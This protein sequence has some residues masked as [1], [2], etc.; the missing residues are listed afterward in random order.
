MSVGVMVLLSACLGEPDNSFG[1]RLKQDINSI[2]AHLSSNGLLDDAI[3]DI[4]GVRYTIET[5]G[6]GY[7]PRITDQVTFDYVGKL[8]DGTVFDSGTLTDFLITNLIPGFQV[9]LPQITVGSSA[10]LYIPSGYGYGAQ[11]K[12]NIPINSILIFSI[13]LKS[14]KLGPNELTRLGAD[15]TAIDNYIT[16]E[17]IE[18]VQKDTTG[19]RYKITEPGIGVVPGLY[20]RVKISYS[21]YLLTNGTKGAK[22]YQGQNQPTSTTDSRVANYIRGFQY[23]LM[24]LPK[25]SK[26]TF[27]IPSG[28]GFGEQAVSGALVPI[29]AN[30]ILIYDVELIDVYDPNP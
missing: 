29:P 2:D 22:F 6:T 1:E 9:G 12:P 16:N 19:L 26:A 15:T 13:T 28:M 23:G 24:K 20:N 7:P 30:S 27:Y 17:A 25:G 11:A 3:K 10:T 14:I 4:S 21:G 5:S 18:N 8:I